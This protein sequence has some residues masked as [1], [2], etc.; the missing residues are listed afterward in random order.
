[1]KW[2]VKRIKEAKGRGWFS[3]MNCRLGNAWMN[4]I[5]ESKGLSNAFE[6]KHSIEIL[7]REKNDRL[8]N[9]LTWFDSEL[10]ALD[11]T[12][13]C[14]HFFSSFEE[15][16]FQVSQIYWTVNH[17][18]T[19]SFIFVQIFFPGS[20]VS[21]LIVSINKCW[22]KWQKC[23]HFH[24]SIFKRWNKE[25]EIQKW[26]RKME[27]ITTNDINGVLSICSF[28]FFPLQTVS[29]WTLT[30]LCRITFAFIPGL[31]WFMYLFSFLD[32]SEPWNS[33]WF[34]CIGNRSIAPKRRWW[35][36]KS[37]SFG[38]KITV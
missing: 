10:Q 5:C 33:I 8:E 20:L 9:G 7:D 27:S 11:I 22:N 4:K 30:A 15:Y 19:V 12:Q 17:V 25:C 24:L 1:M 13:N 23:K 26:Q 34:T 35:W 21:F 16:R 36:R 3:D 29:Q 37:T 32:T 6:F 18:E 28:Y 38:Y 14:S 2:N 31:F